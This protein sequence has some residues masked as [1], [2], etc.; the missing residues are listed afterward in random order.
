MKGDQIGTLTAHPSLQE[1]SLSN[2]TWFNAG[3]DC[4]GSPTCGRGHLGPG[5]REGDPEVPPRH[6][7]SRAGQVRPSEHPGGRSG[8]RVSA[9]P[10]LAPRAGTLLKVGHDPVRD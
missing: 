2:W 4:V 5:R 9:T 6:A 7:L 10:R 3:A 8:W 1:L